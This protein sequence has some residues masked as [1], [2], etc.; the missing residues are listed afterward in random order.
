[1]L[2][3]ALAACASLP[4]SVERVPTQAYTDTAGT[5]LGRAVETASASHPGLTAVHPLSAG[6]DA[7]AAR[8]ALARAAQR[9]LDVQ[10]YIWHPDTSGGLLAQAIWEAAERGVRVRMLLDDQ[11]TKGM[12]PTIAVL[13]GH[14]NI[15]VRLFNPFAS[16]SL[17]LGDYVTDFSRV[18]RRMHN[19]SFTA[20]NQVSVV[21][22]RNVGDEYLGAET[23]VAFTDLDVIVAGRVAHD[24]SATFDHYW[25]SPSAYPAA[26]LIPAPTGEL[27]AQVLGQ[28]EQLQDSP[29]A[30]RYLEAVRNQPFVA[31]I[32]SGDVPWEWVPARV[33]SDDPAKVLEPPEDTEHDLLPRLSQAL[34]EPERELLLVSPYFVPGPDG[35]AA[36]V[37]LAKRGVK[38]SVLTNSLAATD[39]GP[40]YAGYSKYRSALLRGGVQLWELKPGAQPPQERDRRGSGVGGSSGGSSSGASLHAKTFAVDRERIFVGSFN[41]DPRSSKLNTEMGVVLESR[42]LASQLARAFDENVPQD[43]YEVRLAADGHSVEWIE[44]TPSGQVRHTST[45]GSGPLR[46]LGIGVMSILPIEWL[47]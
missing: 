19:K 4:R 25:N 31:Q 24:I 22:G 46:M 43:A 7:F 29:Q 18:N 36:L 41:L 16:R 8:Y 23:A 6:R 27:R 13:D 34:G 47:L 9:S 32:L 11:N 35:T 5:R 10:Y 2:L 33:V 39:V 30:A 14:P 15:E 17:R 45:P 3:A 21:G 42:A 12:D 26:S 38:V 1:M 44:R 20:D 40:V 28:W 37:A